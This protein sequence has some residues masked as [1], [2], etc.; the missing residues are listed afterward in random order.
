[1]DS[2]ERLKRL[3]LELP[4]LS[5]NKSVTIDQF[6]KTFSISQEQAV[7]DLTLLTFVGPSQFG[8]DLVDIQISDEIITVVDNQKHGNSMRFTPEELMV[9]I[10]SLNLLIQGDQTNLTLKSLN[11]KIISVFYKETSE[12][13]NKYENILNVLQ[14]SIESKKLINM[15]Y[16]DGRNYVK[17]NVLIKVLAIDDMGGFKYLQGIDCKNNST[18]SYR[19]DRILRVSLSDEKHDI[20][21]NSLV[22]RE[23]FDVNIVAPYWKKSIIE[24][25]NLENVQYENNTLDFHLTFFDFNFVKTLI[26][27]LGSQIKVKADKSVKNEILGLIKQDIDRLS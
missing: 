21:S 18:K 27:S 8:G 16:I 2:S 7:K 22:D 6:C 24:K 14:N 1:M 13:Q 17:Q 19:L 20:A 9:L 23:S 15:D 10:A 5:K 12:K 25:F 4:W 3:I 26:Y 11:D